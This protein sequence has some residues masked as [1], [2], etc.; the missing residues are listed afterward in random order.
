MSDSATP[1]ERARPFRP[2]LELTEVWTGLLL[3]PGSWVADFMVH[4]FLV[5]FTSIHRVRW[6]LRLSTA[7][8]LA[9]LFVGAF[10]CWRARRRSGAAARGDQRTDADVEITTLANWGLALAAYFFLLILATFYTSLVIDVRE[11][12]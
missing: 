1:A 5:R 11:I 9:L 12:A 2:S 6:P 7:A 4:Y 3:A 10:L 8:S